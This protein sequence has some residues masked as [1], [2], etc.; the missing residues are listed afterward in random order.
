MNGKGPR[1]TMPQP[2][3][4]QSI[5]LLVEPHVVHVQPA[6]AHRVA[7]PEADLGTAVRDA[8]V[9]ND[10]F[11]VAA[12][13]GELRDATRCA[14]VLDVE[15]VLARGALHPGPGGVQAVAQAGD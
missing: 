13:P 3:S 12:R 8:D 7:G 15:L 10:Q 2:L 9:A 11:R 5:L 14:V 6:A 4:W 1:H